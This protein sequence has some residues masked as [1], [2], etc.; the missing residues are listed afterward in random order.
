MEVKLGKYRHFKGMEYEVIGVA[1]HSETLAPMVV[2]RALYGEGE[3]W[4]RPL[5]M[6]N[7][8]VTRDG[9]SSPRF[10]YIGD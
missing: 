7:E 4:V 8:I 3:L 10:T 2:Y 5:E 6:W 9:V 1:R